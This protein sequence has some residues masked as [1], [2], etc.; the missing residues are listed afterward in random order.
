MLVYGDTSVVF[1][2]LATVTL[3][4]SVSVRIEHPEILPTLTMRKSESPAR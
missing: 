1:D 3:T 4:H 2:R